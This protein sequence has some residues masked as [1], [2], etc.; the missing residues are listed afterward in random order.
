MDKAR[1]IVGLADTIAEKLARQEPVKLRVSRP[2]V[3]VALLAEAATAD[4]RPEERN[5]ALSVLR[6]LLNQRA[7]SWKGKYPQLA[8]MPLF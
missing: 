7:S 2:S 5:L 6:T 3:V 8:Q 1:K 4:A